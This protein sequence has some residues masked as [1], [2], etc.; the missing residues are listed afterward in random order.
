M[1]PTIIKCIIASF[2][3]LRDFIRL[4]QISKSWNI[5]TKLQSAYPPTEFW[6]LAGL[7]G[8]PHVT[9]VDIKHHHNVDLS[10][11]PIKRIKLRDLIYLVYRYIQLPSSIT[12]IISADYTYD[13]QLFHAL[14]SFGINFNGLQITQQI[15]ASSSTTK[16]DYHP[17]IKHILHADTFTTTW[18]DMDLT[19]VHNLYFKSFNNM[20]T[21]YEAKLSKIPNF[22][23]TYDDDDI[24]KIPKFFQTKITKLIVHNI[25]IEQLIQL[26][27]LR[28]LTLGH[29]TVTIHC[30]QSR[31]A[32][33]PHLNMI[34]SSNSKLLQKLLYLL[35]KNVGPENHFPRSHPTR[36]NRPYLIIVKSS[37]IRQHLAK[38]IA[39]FDLKGVFQI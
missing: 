38:C 31:F 1:F 33:W 17:G 19:G 9:S 28:S 23:I 32:H 22:E 6:P 12:E 21:N 37:A 5:A 10:S 35:Y 13:D 27:E 7:A 16:F 34:H 8:N 11:Y 20:Y 18:L 15:G 14:L 4:R 30:G 25:P 39:E 29:F 2:S 36:C 26:S 24:K 3:N